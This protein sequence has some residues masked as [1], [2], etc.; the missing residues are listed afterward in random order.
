M[1]HTG[2]IRQRD[3]QRATESGRD[4]PRVLPSK[5]QGPVHIQETQKHEQADGK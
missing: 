3:S 1:T 4:T 2:P 5:T